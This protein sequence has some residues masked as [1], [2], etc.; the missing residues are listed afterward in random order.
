MQRLLEVKA[1]SLVTPFHEA[2]KELEEQRSA[3]L[4]P[5]AVY[6]LG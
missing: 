5:F 3:R 6:M 1:S 2:Q 4:W